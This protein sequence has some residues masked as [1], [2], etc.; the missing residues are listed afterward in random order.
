M[1]ARKTYREL[2]FPTVLLFGKPT[3]LSC[4]YIK[5]GDELVYA[6]NRTTPMS[7]THQHEV[8]SSNL[9]FYCLI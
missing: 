9:E 1:S 5:G 4:T 7:D 8:I 6:R 3:I 2:Q